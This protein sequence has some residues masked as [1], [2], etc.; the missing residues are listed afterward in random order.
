MQPSDVIKWTSSSNRHLKPRVTARLVRRPA[1]LAYRPLRAAVRGIDASRAARP[2]EARV[3][4]EPF[5]DR[6][7]E[8]QL[9]REPPQAAAPQQAATDGDDASRSHNPFRRW[10]ASVLVLMGV[11]SGPTGPVGH[12]DQGH[13]LERGAVPEACQASND[14][15]G[16]SGSFGLAIRL[17]DWG[18]LEPSL[19]QEV[20]RRLTPERWGECWW[21]AWW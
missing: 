7:G 12:P 5:A 20:L 11:L 14:A 21:S 9:G 17:S 18:R 19:S 3:V 4:F 10:A 15:R 13:S 6:D 1:W 2:V 8:H 16:V